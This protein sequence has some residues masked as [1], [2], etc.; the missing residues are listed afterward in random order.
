M[1]KFDSAR[2]MAKKIQR[3]VYGEDEDVEED[4]KK[5]STDATD[6]RVNPEEAEAVAENSSS[7]A[8]NAEIK[9]ERI[10]ATTKGTVKTGTKVLDPVAAARAR[11]EAIN[12][13][14]KGGGNKGIEATAGNPDAGEFRAMIEINDFPRMHHDPCHVPILMFYRES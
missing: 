8:L 12:A 5:D 9:V 6:A 4:G 2:D 13:R 7:S 3:R 1:D 14:V 11:I 10:T